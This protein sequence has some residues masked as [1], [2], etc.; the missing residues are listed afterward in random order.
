MPSCFDILWAFLSKP[1]RLLSLLAIVGVVALAFSRGLW[2]Y[3]IDG[4]TPLRKRRQRSRHITLER[5]EASESGSDRAGCQDSK[6]QPSEKIGQAQRE[7]IGV[8]KRS[9]KED[10]DRQ[11]AFAT[12]DAVLVIRRVARKSSSPVSR[13][14]FLR[15]RKPTDCTFSADGQGGRKKTETGGEEAHPKNSQSGNESSPAREVESGRAAFVDF[16]EALCELLSSLPG[17]KAFWVSS[18]DPVVVQAKRGDMSKESGG[19][20]RSADHK[21]TKER[22]L[23]VFTASQ[24]DVF[25]VIR[26]NDKKARRFRPS[27]RHLLGRL[28]GLGASFVAPPCH[29]ETVRRSPDR[30][31]A[32]CLPASSTQS[33]RL[34]YSFLSQN[35][36]RKAERKTRSETGKKIRSGDRARYVSMILKRAR[37]KWGSEHDDL[38][39]SLNT[40]T[41]KLGMTPFGAEE[42]ILDALRER[43]ILREEPLYLHQPVELHS[44]ERIWFSRPPRAFVSTMDILRSIIPSSW[45]ASPVSSS[46]HRILSQPIQAIRLYFGEREALY[47]SFLV[48]YTSWL[49]PSAFVGL[50]VF[51]HQQTLQYYGWE[52]CDGSGRITSWGDRLCRIIPGKGAESAFSLFMA[53]FIALGSTFFL[54]AWKREQ[55]SLVF[56]WYV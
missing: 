53:L 2:D 32:T 49:V 26:A 4:S 9:P 30:R 5:I 34:A 40:A 17:V 48:L 51:L 41:A 43:G 31:K 38:L 7:N 56:W 44:I 29:G 18:E 15:Q 39:I 13:V 19:D 35:I 10:E 36:L 42:L 16:V 21:D 20:D 52:D 28:S 11:I 24:N 27:L 55:N 14:D 1:Q 45:T 23:P 33:N 22:R 47:F 54:E 37:V 12:W 25:V 8:G 50:I 3:I 46:R 6:A